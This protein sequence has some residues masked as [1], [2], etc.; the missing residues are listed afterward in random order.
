MARTC[1]ICWFSAIIVCI[2]CPSVTKQPIRF[3]F[4]CSS[5]ASASSS[6]AAAASIAASFSSS[7]SRFRFF[8]TT[9]IGGSPLGTK[10][11]PCPSPLIIW[12]TGS[13]A[14]Q[15][16]VRLLSADTRVETPPPLG[17]S[18]C[19][20]LFV[21]ALSLLPHRSRR[22]V[23]PSGRS[24]VSKSSIQL[25]SSIPSRRSNTSASKSWSVG[26][27][28]SNGSTSA[29]SSSAALTDAVHSIC[30][31]SSERINAAVRGQRS[32]GDRNDA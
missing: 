28:P 1:F 31:R 16:S 19:P 18:S 24:D 32:R 20:P 26:Q 27:F 21:E 12:C 9:W 10:F 4:S 22:G 13:S 11:S 6:W 29:N 17:A 15:F 30:V 23:I 5:L 3:L 8:G 2:C 7:S 25:G 14:T